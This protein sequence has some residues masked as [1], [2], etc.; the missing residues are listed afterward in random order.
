MYA[1]GTPP[2]L[3]NFPLPYN[4]YLSKMGRSQSA[5]KLSIIILAG[6]N[7]LSKQSPAFPCPLK[8]MLP[9]CNFFLIFFCASTWTQ[10]GARLTYTWTVF[11]PPLSPSPIFTPDP[12][13]LNAN[14]GLLRD[15]PR[16]GKS[17]YRL[18]EAFFFF[19]YVLWRG[20]G[21]G[22]SAG[23]REAI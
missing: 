15:A 18:E 5:F 7:I 8:K 6:N 1:Q 11:T 16:V 22:I 17:I 12:M 20:R 10:T 14:L 4:F 3:D 21:Y 23:Q 2:W 19:V 9:T 13:K